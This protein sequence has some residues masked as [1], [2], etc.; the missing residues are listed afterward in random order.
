MPLSFSDSLLVKPMS[1]DELPVVGTGGR[2]RPLSREPAKCSV[3][4]FAMH[5]MRSRSK[6][7][8]PDLVRGLDHALQALGSERRRAAFGR[9]R[10][11]R[12]INFAIFSAQRFCPRLA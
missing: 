4:L 10:A 12:F 11:L 2:E 8:S 5:F 6:S 1:Q 7:G 3:M 9:C